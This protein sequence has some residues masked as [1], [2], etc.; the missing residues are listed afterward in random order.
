MHSSILVYLRHWRQPGRHTKA[1]WNAPVSAFLTWCMA[2]QMQFG[3]AAAAASHARVLKHTDT[4]V[5]KPQYSVL[6]LRDHKHI[7]FLDFQCKF[8]AVAK[9]GVLSYRL[10]SNFMSG[11]IKEVDCLT[12]HS[13]FCCQ[14]PRHI[15]AELVPHLCFPS[16]Y[17][18]LAFPSPRECRFVWLT[19]VSS[20]ALSPFLSV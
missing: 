2:P 12:C 9:C 4:Q 17:Q 14:L 3:P 20:T 16:Q 5:Y 7:F 13:S 6:H 1:N 11:F 8:I 18:R 15:S 10:Q 19:V